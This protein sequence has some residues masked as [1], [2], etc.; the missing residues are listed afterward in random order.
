MNTWHKS[1]I[2]GSDFPV[3]G[4]DP[5][6]I[7]RVNE[8]IERYERYAQEHPNNN[9]SDLLSYQRQGVSFDWESRV[10][11]M[12]SFL[13]DFDIPEKSGKM[14]Y[15]Y[16]VYLAV[17]LYRKLPFNF[18]GL[19]E[20]LRRQ[21]EKTIGL[22]LSGDVDKLEHLVRQAYDPDIDNKLKAGKEAETKLND[23]IKMNA[24]K[25]LGYTERHQKYIEER[26]K[27][28]AALEGIQK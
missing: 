1:V 17:R 12:I 23:A 8:G 26:K 6:T 4:A 14:S 22:D 20:A 2:A 7:A 28:A 11:V 3:T 13:E 10:R 19:R 27:R 5:D 25:R 24:A 16:N 18:D 9:E 21:I 15:R